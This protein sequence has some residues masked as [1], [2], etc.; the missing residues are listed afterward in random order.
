VCGMFARCLQPAA[1]DPP[2]SIAASLLHTPARA[3]QYTSHLHGTVQNNAGRGWT[4][5][6]LLA[7]DE[8][9]SAHRCIPAARL[10]DQTVCPAACGPFRQRAAAAAAAAAANSRRKRAAGVKASM[11]CLLPPASRP[12]IGHLQQLQLTADGEPRQPT[13]RRA[14]IRP[15]TWAAS[16]PPAGAGAAPSWKSRRRAA[17][18]STW[19]ARRRAA[20]GGT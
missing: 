9:C 5:C 8:W 12:S 14:A 3:H 10:S 18:R 15:G 6:S 20:A 7:G 1:S 16:A 4:C 17:G 2:H 13:T 19:A 11:P